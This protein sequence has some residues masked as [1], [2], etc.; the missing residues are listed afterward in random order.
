MAISAPAPANRQSQTSTTPQRHVWVITPQG[1][2]LVRTDLPT[3]TVV[4]LVRN[5]VHELSRC[6]DALFNQD[7]PPDLV[8]VLVVDNGSTDGSREVVALYRHLH[9][10][11]R[12][13]ANPGG[14]FPKGLNRALQEAK[15]EI[16][17]RLEGNMVVPPDFLRRCVA[18]LRAGK[19]AALGVPVELHSVSQDTQ[20]IAVALGHPL[21]G[22]LTTLWG[23]WPRAK[24]PSRPY[25]TAWPKR[26][27]EALGGFGPPYPVPDDLPLYSR[28]RQDGGS[29]AWLPAVGV[30]QGLSPGWRQLAQ[31][32]VRA[33]YWTA[34]WL[35]WQRRFLPLR[36][37]TLPAL[38]FA[39]WTL[40]V[41]G[42]HISWAARAAGAL[43]WGYMGFTALLAAI[44]SGVR[45]P[46]LWWSVWLAVV[47]IH[48]AWGMGFWAGLLLP[49]SHNA[50]SDSREKCR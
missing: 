33:G 29:I 21:G 17:V 48:W 49:R 27:L 11:L 23:K 18:A 5:H 2:T 44:I 38:V 35:R 25:L 19:W 32:R 43:I 37:L 50:E 42:W 14:A 39:F 36:L 31:E 30:Q 13:L 6:L 45:R 10:N 28:L 15:G 12:L 3:V 22:G 1:W 8:E 4:V 24:K 41:L 9:P 16:F 34:R 7:Y 47:I 40:W 26:T 20:A 46:R